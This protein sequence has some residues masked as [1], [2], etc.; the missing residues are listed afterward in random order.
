MCCLCPEVQTG[1][2]VLQTG[3]PMAQLQIL[4]KLEAAYGED[5]EFFTLNQQED[6][7]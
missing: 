3:W 7:D 4:T 5:I 1:V 2:S 6:L